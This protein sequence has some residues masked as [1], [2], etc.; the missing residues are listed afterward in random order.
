MPAF[1]PRSR[2]FLRDVSIISTSSE[3]PS[4]E[5]NVSLGSET[6]SRPRGTLPN[7]L[8]THIYAVALIALLAA[9]VAVRFS[10]LFRL[11]RVSR[12]KRRTVPSSHCAGSRPTSLGLVTPANSARPESGG[13]CQGGGCEKEGISNAQTDEWPCRSDLEPVRLGHRAGGF[14][15]STVP[16]T[17]LPH[18]QQ[19]QKQQQQQ[20]PQDQGSRH[21]PKSWEMV[22]SRS[23][24]VSTKDRA[25]SGAHSSQT[26]S[27][28][29]AAA[30]EKDAGQSY[31]VPHPDPS[32]FSQPRGT[33]EPDVGPQDGSTMEGGDNWSGA[34]ALDALASQQ[35]R[36]DASSTAQWS[37]SSATA[38]HSMPATLSSA[39]ASSSV[40]AAGVTPDYYTGGSRDLDFGPVR[41]GQATP[42][43]S[44]GAPPPLD[45][46]SHFPSVFAFQD[47]RPAYAASIPPELDGG[48][49]RLS[50][51]QQ[52]HAD[53]MSA[54]MPDMGMVS[55]TASFSRQS[56][57]STSAGFATG[58]SQAGRWTPRRRSYNRVV[59]SGSESD[60][61]PATYGTAGEEVGYG[62]EQQQW[63]AGGFS[64]YPS[65][66]HFAPA[67]F[68]ST[69]TTYL[70]PPPPGSGDYGRDATFFDQNYQQYPRPLAHQQRQHG[71]Y[72]APALSSHRDQEQGHGGAGADEEIASIDD[73][74]SASWKRHTR[75]HDGGVCLACLANGGGFYG[76]T[77]PLEERRPR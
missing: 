9:V 32:F 26:R 38:A 75:V 73:E 1:I 58:G 11:A 7:L 19:Q 69:D 41:L 42:H 6:D 5:H 44:V 56:S 22:D 15:E 35:A 2:L 53:Y 12:H 14:G 39:S 62:G 21:Q 40:A 48:D 24:G 8:C 33:H 57:S 13:G 77:V 25:G 43:Q 55:D 28:A 59:S 60:P 18:P 72:D 37:G 30:A 3:T 23:R 63:Q 54:G 50:F 65:L 66:R 68:P 71:L 47:R 34:S 67:S 36:S 17:R 46:E 4:Q 10:F 49:T 31:R 76:D 51:L 52:P 64:T 45:P 70:P 27:A 74:A 29:A 20:Q 61:A 16:Q